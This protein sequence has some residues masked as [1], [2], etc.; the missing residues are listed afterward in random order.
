MK[1]GDT[2]RFLNDIGGGKVTRI[3][4]KT[5]YVVD[6]DGFET[7]VLQTQCVVVPSA[8]S[9]PHLTLPTTSRV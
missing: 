2:V 5:A 7:P 4:G 6:A 1:I 3:E 8:V 9:Y